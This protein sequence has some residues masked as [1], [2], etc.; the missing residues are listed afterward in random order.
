MQRF[1]CLKQMIFSCCENLKISP[2]IVGLHCL[3][4]LSFSLCPNLMG[5]DSTI[6]DLE[7]LRNLNLTSCYNIRKLPK[8]ICDLRSLETLNLNVC[9]KLKELRNDLGKLECLREV[10]VVATAITEVPNALGHSKNLEM[11]LLSRDFL[12]K[13]QSRVLDILPAWLQP[14]KSLSQLG[15]LPSSLKTLQLENCNLCEVEVPYN[16][17]SL[18]SL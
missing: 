11:L 9:S 6:G 17:E 14:Q 5:L 1:K 4:V 16:L 18:S 12:F 13:E 15:F 3:E 10:D 8:R 7:R 2:K